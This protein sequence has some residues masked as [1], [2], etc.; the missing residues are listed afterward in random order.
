ML[1]SHPLRFI[2]SVATL[3]LVTFGFTFVAGADAPTRTPN[4]QSQLSFDDLCA[5]PVVID[6]LVNKEYVTTFTSG[7]KD[8]Q[9]L[10]TGALK[11]RVT[12]VPTHK[13]VDLNVS[14]PIQ[15]IPHE[16]GTVSVISLGATLWPFTDPQPGLPRLAVVD[17]RLEAVFDPTF[18]V[19][20]VQAHVVDVCA[21]LS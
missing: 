11:V 17:G 2:V 4:P 6:I 8:Q 16:D 21:L 15:V 12:N 5:F 13:A 20:S 7:P 10:I 3:I 14:G 9:Q 19:T 18:R 1:K